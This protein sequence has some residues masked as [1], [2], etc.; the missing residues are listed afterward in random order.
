M[1]GG[2]L[3]GGRDLDRLRLPQA[4]LGE[5]REPAQR[6]DLVVEEVDA[7]GA[8]LG[9]RVE[10]EQ[11]AADGELAAVLDLV[12]ALVA[13]GD[14]V[15]RALVEVE[16]LADAQHEA[17]RAQLRV[18]DLLRERDGGDDDDRRLAARRLDQRIQRRDAEADEMRRRR[19][20][21][22]V[23]DAAAR[24]EAHGPRLEPRAEV[25][26]EVAGA[27]VVAGDDERRR[28]RVAVGEGGED[29][30]PQRLRDERAAAVAASPA[31]A[32]SWSN[33]SRSGRR[34]TGAGT[35]NGRAGPRGGVLARV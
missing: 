11:P 4:A 27:A 15:G 10:V 21:G 14:E 17:V 9:R 30:R 6:L 32:G 13:R 7:D 3:G 18:R 35:P 12:D 8:L 29:E 24:I 34:D 2:Q 5:G 1:L 25:L 31:A 28:G 16:Q 19:E 20:V 33:W 26:R 22:L 23:R